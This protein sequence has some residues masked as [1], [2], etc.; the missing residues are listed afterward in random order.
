VL[1]G[2]RERAS[3]LIA[4]LAR[5]EVLAAPIGELITP[6]AS[7]I[8]ELSIRDQLPQIEVAVGDEAAALVLRVLAAPSEEDLGG[9]ARSKRS[10]ECACFCRPAASIP[11]G[12]VRAV[13]TTVLFTAEAASN[14]NSHRPIS[15]RSMRRPIGAGRRAGTCWN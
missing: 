9:C 5:C 15:S 14:W 8:G 11:C 4:Q 1:V 6:L 13:C 2:F 12:T 7:L 10:T 3:H